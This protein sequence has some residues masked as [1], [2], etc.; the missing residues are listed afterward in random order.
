ME[1]QVRHL[2]DPLDDEGAMGIKY[3]LT[4]TAHLARRGRAGR[5]LPL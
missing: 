5:S 3:G 4:V 1:R 2:R